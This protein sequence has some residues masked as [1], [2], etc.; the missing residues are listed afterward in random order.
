[1]VYKEEGRESIKPKYTNSCGTESLYPHPAQVQEDAGEEVTAG[2]SSVIGSIT[3][4]ASCPSPWY[5]IPALTGYIELVE[6]NEPAMS[7]SF[8]RS[9][10]SQNTTSLKVGEEISFMAGFYYYENAQNV[11]AFGINKDAMTWILTDSAIT[12]LVAVATTATI[13]AAFL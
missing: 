10:E 7:C 11:T 3:D 5:K 6:I 9:F 13:F 4:A 2:P 12:S 1:M 8:Y